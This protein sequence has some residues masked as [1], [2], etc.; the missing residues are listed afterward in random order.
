MAASAD[1]RKP[2]QLDLNRVIKMSSD[3]DLCDTEGRGKFRQRV[4]RH[5]DTVST[6]DIRTQAPHCNA[7]TLRS[8]ALRILADSW[9]IKLLARRLNPTGRAA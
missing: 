5:Y 3:L 6:G 2:N 7:T 1:T 4:Q 8:D 9:I